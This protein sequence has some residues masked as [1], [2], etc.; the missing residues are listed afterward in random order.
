[1][2]YIFS[3]LFGL[4]DNLTIRRTDP[5]ARDIQLAMGETIISEIDINHFQS[6]ALGFI[7]FHRV[8]YLNRKLDTF[9]MKLVIWWYHGNTWNKDSLP[10]VD[11]SEDCGFYYVPMQSLHL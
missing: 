7:N 5:G 3:V 1:M 8:A 6:L 10:L 2:N 11:A 9:K 4:E